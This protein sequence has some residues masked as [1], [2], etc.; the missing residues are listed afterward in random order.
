MMDNCFKPLSASSV[1]GQ[2]ATIKLL[3][4][5]AAPANS[6]VTPEPARHDRKNGAATTQRKVR[7]A[8]DISALNPVT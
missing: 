5:D 7:W 6:R 2:N 4:E 8:T 3:A 1:T